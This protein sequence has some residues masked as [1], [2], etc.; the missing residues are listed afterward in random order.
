MFKISVS[1]FLSVVKIN[2][3]GKSDPKT[4]KYLSIFKDNKN[5]L[6]F[7]F[8][9]GRYQLFWLSKRRPLKALELFLCTIY[10]CFL[11]KIANL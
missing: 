9:L 8:M 3:Y 7:Q 6:K 2:I 5:R 4:Q 1:G 10:F 11:G